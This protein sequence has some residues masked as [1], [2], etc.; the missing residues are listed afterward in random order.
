M[1]NACAV[2]DVQLFGNICFRCNNII[3]GDGR[4]LLLLEQ[5]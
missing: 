3:P 5:N 2:V 1:S 4:L